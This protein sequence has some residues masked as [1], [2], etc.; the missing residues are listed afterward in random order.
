[1]L[2]MNES[3]LQELLNDDRRRVGVLERKI[4]LMKEEFEVEKQRLEGERDREMMKRSELQ[5]QLF[6]RF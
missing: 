5:K 3:K 6:R 2:S 1:M 4:K